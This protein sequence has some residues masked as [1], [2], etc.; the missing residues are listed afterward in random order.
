ML[1]FFGIVPVNGYGRSSEGATEELRIT[2]VKG[3]S[4]M[5]RF[6]TSTLISIGG[7]IIP[8]IPTNRLVAG[9]QVI[10]II[11]INRPIASGLVVPFIL[12]GGLVASIVFT[13]TLSDSTI[14]STTK[15]SSSEV[16]IFS[17]SIE[18]FSSG[19]LS[20]FSKDGAWVTNRATS[21]FIETSA[22]AGMMGRSIGANGGIA[23]GSTCWPSKPRGRSSMQLS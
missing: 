22:G 23:G 7:L 12:Y 1:D 4:W 10:P 21:P 5:R 2:F 3:S 6:T 11:P 15:A 19:L 8:I 9:G 13:K 18:T 16:V 17:T 20:P 14:A